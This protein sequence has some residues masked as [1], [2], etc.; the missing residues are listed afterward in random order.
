MPQCRLAAA[1]GR[2]GGAGVTA[3]PQ[4]AA[5]LRMGAPVLLLTAATTA[6]PAQRPVEAACDVY[7]TATAA[8]ANVVAHV[9]AAGAGQEAA[10]TVVASIAAAQATVRASLSAA[11]Y[12]LER[13]LLVCLGPGRHDVPGDAPLSFG[14]TLDSPRAGA[15][16][17]V[18]RGSGNKADP[19]KVTGGVQVTGW[20]SAT[21]GGGAAFAAAVPAG[22][23]AKLTAIRQ[24]WVNE[25]RANRTSMETVV[26]CSTGC[27]TPDASKGATGD[28][29]RFVPDC[30]C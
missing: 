27:T 4:P 10:G 5:M 14:G 2:C 30:S 18:W 19:S 16:R 12:E 28:H 25:K 29:F 6:A 21:L 20:K 17:V 8:N 26:D 24:L 9:A 1:E 22:A 23:A 15:G 11:S 3:E 13:D 7:V